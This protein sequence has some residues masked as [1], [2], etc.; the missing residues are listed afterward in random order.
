[1]RVREQLGRQ[2]GRPPAR[3]HDRLRK[4]A[5]LRVFAAIDQELRV[6]QHRREQVVEVVRDAARQDAQAVQTLALL[7]RELQRAALLLL[8]LRFAQVA[9]GRHARR[10]AM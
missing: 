4:L 10:L 3:V 2:T 5:L 9:D 1:A 6:P 7:E 8:A